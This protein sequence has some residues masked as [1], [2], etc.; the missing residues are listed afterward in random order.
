M[1]ILVGDI[2]P[3]QE[4]GLFLILVTS[5]KE[6]KARAADVIM[7]GYFATNFC[8]HKSLFRVNCPVTA[9]QFTIP[10]FTLVKYFIAWVRN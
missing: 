7:V 9:S 4:I 5:L 8:Q 2:Y 1:C 6:A 3:E 10:H